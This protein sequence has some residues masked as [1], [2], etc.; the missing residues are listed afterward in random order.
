M[1][2]QFTGKE[3]PGG[4][5]DLSGR[6]GLALVVF[7]QAGSFYS[8][9]LKYVIHEGVHD[10]H[11]FAA[12]TVVRVDLLQNF[13]DVD[14]ERFLILPPAILNAGR[15][16]SFLSS[17][18]FVFLSGYRGHF[19]SVQQINRYINLFVK[20]LRCKFSLVVFVM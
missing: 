8:D 16:T 2:S 15:S 19:S 18:L 4:S 6:Y 11:S 7:Y 5:L 12:N 9:P 10:R 1:L 14:R 13:V 17:L 3:Q 20:R